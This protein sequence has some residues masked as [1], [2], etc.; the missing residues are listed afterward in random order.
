[1]LWREIQAIAVDFLAALLDQV[2][3]QTHGITKKPKQTQKL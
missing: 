1:L 2:S 3:G